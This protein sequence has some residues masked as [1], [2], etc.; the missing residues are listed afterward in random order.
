MSVL[1]TFVHDPLLEWKKGNKVGRSLRGNPVV[2]LIVC[3]TRLLQAQQGNSTDQ[4]NE[5]AVRNLATIKNKLDG[6]VGVLSRNSQGPTLPLSV[7][8]HV[9]ELIGLA[10]DPWNLARSY[11]GW[12]AHA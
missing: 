8:G 1:E 12:A 3:N 9:R 6:F 2:H 10:T 4:R 11:I 5:I 7:E